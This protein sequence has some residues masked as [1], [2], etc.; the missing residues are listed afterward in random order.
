MLA[1]APRAVPTE[2]SRARGPGRRPPGGCCDRHSENVGLCETIL[3]PWT[4]TFPKPSRRACQRGLVRPE[5]A[6]GRDGPLRVGRSPCVR[7]APA[8]HQRRGGSMERRL[9]FA[10]SSR[11]TRSASTTITK[12]NCAVADESTSVGVQGESGSIGRGCV[13]H[14]RAREV[15]GGLRPSSRRQSRKLSETY[16]TRRTRSLRAPAS[17][18]RTNPSDSSLSHVSPRILGRFVVDS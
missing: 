10:A 14:V 8:H 7:G 17:R 9:R 11:Q 6:L 1:V 15:L 4:T 5:Q 2:T 13:N 18:P 16:L 3:S 12:S